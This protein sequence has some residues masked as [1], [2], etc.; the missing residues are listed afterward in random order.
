MELLLSCESLTK[1]FGAHALFQGISMGLFEGERT[2][3][4]GPNGAGKSTFMKILAGQ[5]RCDSGKIVSRRGLRMGFVAQQD[6][7]EED[8]TVESVLAGALAGDHIEERERLAQVSMMLGR[9]GFARRDQLASTLSG[10]WRKRLAIGRELIHKPDLLLLDEPTNHLDLEGIEWLED[11]LADAP[12]AF[13]VVTHDRYFLE[14]VTNRV[15]EL[16]AAYPEG[17]F[18]TNGTYSQFLERREEFLT[19][20]A[21]LQA[22]IA[23]KVRREIEWL[24]RGAKARTT[25]AKGRIEEAGRLIGELAE[26]K[27]RNAYGRTIEIDFAATQRQTRKLIAAKGIE[28]TL[29]GRTLFKNLSFVLSPGMKLGLLGPNGCG[30]TTLLRLMAGQL[31]PDR[32]EIKSAEGLRVVLFD[33]HRQQLDPN[34]S[35][36][37]ALSPRSE[38]VI[39]QDKPMHISS[40]AK[41]FLFRTEQL[42]LAVG[43]LSGGEQARILIA[44]LMLQPADLLIL[45]EPTNDL[46]IPSLEVLEDSLEEFPGAVVLVTHDRHMLDRMCTQL[47]GLDGLGGAGLYADYL[48]WE[49]ARDVALELAKEAQRAARQQAKSSAD[50]PKSSGKR[51]TWNEQREWEQMEA[52]V[53][54]AEGEVEAC[55]QAMT[56]PAVLA[57]RNQ[58]AECCDRMRAA[59]ELVQKLYS[60]WEQ[61][62]TKQR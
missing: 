9:M 30:K 7:F 18:S 44:K 11:L 36:R 21:S 19:G 56:D 38:I 46:D 48:Q 40:W 43:Q 3:L 61:L 5:E 31:E 41:K 49:R 55:H 2:G 4:I 27:A 35:L 58:L 51:L 59:Q 33:Q 24:H 45:D 23:G 22:S 14:N 62:E 54:A 50:K 16:N 29:G 6:A 12:F 34:Q 20:Q 32:G 26:L 37:E 25:K 17:N 60:R 42:D 15:V 10:G 1:S 47:L 8:E 28:K 53:M 52:K 57:D 13:V 39:F